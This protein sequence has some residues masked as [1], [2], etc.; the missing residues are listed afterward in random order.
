MDP[1]R[2]IGALPSRTCMRIGDEARDLPVGGGT[3]PW[4]R[5]GAWEEAGVCDSSSLVEAAELFADVVCG[6]ELLVDELFRAEPP[7]MGK[8]P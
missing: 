2:G 6:P 8:R 3:P 5:A 7:C 1:G 4:A